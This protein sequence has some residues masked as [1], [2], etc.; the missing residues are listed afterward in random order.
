M[1]SFILQPCSAQERG[2]DKAI[3]DQKPLI[4]IYLFPSLYWAGI[5]IERFNFNNFNLVEF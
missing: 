4:Y 3:W 1:C 5:I 2:G